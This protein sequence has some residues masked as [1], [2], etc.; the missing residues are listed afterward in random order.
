MNL[1]K[2]YILLIAMS[3][4]LLISVGSVC[5]VDNSTADAD[6]QLTT[7]Q[8][9]VVLPVGDENT[10]ATEIDAVDEISINEGEIINTTVTV[11]NKD[12]GS[13]IEA[14][15]SNFEVYNGQD[16][17]TFTYENS[18]LIIT[19]TLTAGKY[20]LMISY[21]GDETTFSSSSKNITLNVLKI[22]I[23]SPNSTNIN[24]TNI[25]KIPLNVTNGIEVLNITKNDLSIQITY[26]DGNETKTKEISAFDYQNGILSFNFDNKTVTS[27]SIILKY[28]NETS[29]TI[30]FKRVVNAKFELLTKEI[31]YKNGKVIVRLIDLDDPNN[32]LANKKI[33]LYFDGNIR[34]G[35][36][37][38]TNASGYATWDAKNLY[39]FDRDG[40][41]LDQ[42]QLDIKTYGISIENTNDGTY[43][44]S[45]V[46]SNLTVKQTTAIVTI[47]NYKHEYGSLVPIEIQAKFKNGNPVNGE[48]LKVYVPQSNAKTLYV[49]TD[50]NGTG[51]LNITGFTSGSYEITATMNDT[52]RFKSN[53]DSK[54][55]VI[56]KKEVKLSTNDVTLYFNTGNTAT[57]KVLDKTTGKGVDNAIVRVIIYT[58]S[59]KTFDG[60]VQADKNGVA[61][62]TTS[63]AVG[64][65]TIVLSMDNNEPRYKASQ[66]KKTITVLKHNARF[67]A[68]YTSC[69]YKEGKYFTVKLIS[70]KNKK[71]IYN[72]HV[73][74]RIMLSGGRYYQLSG[75]TGLDGTFRFKINLNPGVYTVYVNGMDGRNYTVSQLKTTIKV[76]KTPT[77][78]VPTALTAKYKSNSFFKVKAINTKLNKGI[79]G[80]KIG[81]QIYTGKYYKVYYATTNAQGIAQFSTKFL[82]LGYHKAV[83]YS[84]IKYCSAKIAT[85][86]IRIVK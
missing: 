33:N 24:S 25:V 9:D 8:S 18:Q 38:N 75:Y 7:P 45:T 14:S 12:N 4:F 55:F 62:L 10:I 56:D 52:K 39:T 29:K 77:K 67:Y 23:D 82:S 16:Q 53:I 68:P 71:V 84:T 48:I 50:G 83:A 44:A 66:V 47:K 26:K 3:I 80:L 64:K 17:M 43:V 59:K 85:S 20:N 76:V 73:K 46:K 69:Y 28:L 1:K 63:L 74:V 79:A 51:K 11:K 21:I 72:G 65:H 13:A 22:T 37:G 49:Q 6:N 61:T 30:T 42:M 86:A 57:I 2:T 27:G 5:A 19:D 31:E 15:Q 32:I 35:F 54:N 34:T 70:N 81:L 36:N 78:L 41:N 60:Y 58:G 40:S